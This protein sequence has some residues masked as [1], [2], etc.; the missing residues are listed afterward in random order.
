MNSKFGL[1]ASISGTIFIL[2][3]CF[4]PLLVISLGAI[5]L[6]AL[7]GY[8][9]YVL[10]PALGVMIGLT[11]WSYSRYRRDRKRCKH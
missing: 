1:L 5:G 10:L 4:T 8:L 3:C 6:G 2:L 11:I 7:T 9:D